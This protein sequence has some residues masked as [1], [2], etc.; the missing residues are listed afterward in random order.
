MRFFRVGICCLLAF[1]V[2]SFG[3]VEEWSQAVLEVGASHPSG[4]M[5]RTA[6]PSEIGTIGHTSGIFAAFCSC[7]RDCRAAGIFPYRLPLSHRIELQLLIAD[8]VF[9]L[10]ISQAFYQRGHWRAF[11]WFLMTLGF[12]V[13]VVGILQN[14][15][16]NGKLYWFRV[17]R[18]GG[19]PFGPYV[20][21]TTL[22]ASPK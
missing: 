20:I 12:F 9:V 1:A 16:F 7:P 21:G 17:M 8:L 19:L 11:V 5:G 15:T 3:A 6:I 22:R 14:L 13:S 2:L 10:L 4:A 18:Y